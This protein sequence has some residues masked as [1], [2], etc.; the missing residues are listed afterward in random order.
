MLPERD[1]NR[2]ILKSC[3]IYKICEFFLYRLKTPICTLTRQGQLS[4]LKYCLVYYVQ[5]AEVLASGIVHLFH[6]FIARADM[7]VFCACLYNLKFTRITET[8]PK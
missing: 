3:I 4:R 5:L 8:P 1:F 6:R 2:Y 7:R